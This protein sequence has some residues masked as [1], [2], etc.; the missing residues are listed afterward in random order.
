[1]ESPMYD[2]NAKREKLKAAGFVV[3]SLLI[4]LGILW[5]V[6]KA[7]AGEL[8]DLTRTPGGSGEVLNPITINSFALDY[9]ASDVSLCND[10]VPGAVDT[11]S[12]VF[13]TNVTDNRVIYSELFDPS[14]V[15]I[16]SFNN[17]QFSLP[18]GETVTRVRVVC[19]PSTNINGGLITDAF[20]VFDVYS[21][22]YAG[23]YLTA[24][25]QFSN[26]TWGQGGIFGTTSMLA[27]VTS[28][29]VATG[30]NVWPLF[31]IVGVP[32]AFFLAFL[33]I[34]FVIT[35]V[36]ARKRKDFEK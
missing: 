19:L 31:A 2:Y 28:G 22:F 24:V 26:A 30:A 8:L 23:G 14:Q 20:A 9:L 35:S 33:L 4:C 13:D 11:I 16:W 7:S 3:F 25:D 12:L 36:G 27:A 17:Y 10:V 18:D 29:A 5:G 21:Q 1:M 6:Q 32:V 34:Q 15:Q